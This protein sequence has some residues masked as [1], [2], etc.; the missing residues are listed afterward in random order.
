MVGHF[1]PGEA[2]LAAQGRVFI[3][4]CGYG[5]AANWQHLEGEARQVISSYKYAPYGS[6][7]YPCPAALAA[8]VV[9]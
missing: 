2:Y 6:E 3:V 1:Q 8:Q 9:R 7:F 4:R 5:E